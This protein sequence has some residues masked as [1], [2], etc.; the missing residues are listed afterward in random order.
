MNHSTKV[1]VIYHEVLFILNWSTAALQCCVSFHSTTKPISHMYTYIPSLLGFPPSHSPSHPHRSS[2]SRELSSLP[3]QPVL[4]GHLFSD[5]V[6]YTR[7]PQ[8]SNSALLPPP[9]LVHSLYLHP[10]SCPA[11][12]FI[13]TIFLDSTDEWIKIW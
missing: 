12:R 3:A 13:C 7:Q 6:K 5:V 9:P 11:N 4:T 10:Y 8:S 1:V 2:Q